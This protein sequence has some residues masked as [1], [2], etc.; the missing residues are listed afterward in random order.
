M[1]ST[2]KSVQVIGGGFSGLAAA[3]CL[4]A[5]GHE[6]NLYEKNATTGGRARAFEREG[7]LF[8]MGPSWYWMPEIIEHFFNR[9]GRSAADYYTLKL[10]D[11]S[12]RV[13]FADG[14]MDVPASYE[15][16]R[17]L[18]ES[19][20]PGSAPR[21]DRFMTEAREK[22]ETGMSRFV[23]K[24]SLN[25]TEYMHPSL[26]GKVWQLDLFSSVSR[27]V[28]KYF[29][30][31]KLIDLLEFPVLFLGAK[32]SRTPALY[33]LMNYADLKLGT[34]YPMGGMVKLPE[35]ITR[36]AAE[37]GVHIHTGAPVSAIHAERGR[38]SAI[39]VNGERLASDAVLAA[40]D[41]HHTDQVLLRENDRSYSRNYWK[42][43][44]MSPSSLLFYVGLSKK[45]PGLRHH[46]LFFDE[47]F[48]PHADSIYGTPAW[49]DKPR[50]YACCPSVTDPSVAPEGM[51]NLFLLIPAATNLQSD[52]SRREAYFK[53]L[54]GRMEKLT[55]QE[56]L[57]HVRFYQSYAHEEFI[58]DYNAF[59]GNAYGLANTLRQT[60][61]LKPAMKSRKLSNLFFAGQLTVPGPGVPPALI[62]GQLAARLISGVPYTYPSNILSAKA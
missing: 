51:E 43:R 19:V 45:I 13:F 40:C 36:M 57:P 12:Y 15:E 44:T 47:S 53:Q 26:L 33:T 46:N 4:A 42:S 34:W 21:L 25:M 3:C 37:L 54:I 27:H 61:W 35:A 6:V 30:N 55:V 24:P 23:W 8:D 1:S 49:P 2:K 31:P 48:G 60:A 9:F 5:E 62:S 11:P 56:I 41:Y 58:R 39:E 7:F 50:F 10:L 32:P 22:Y 17:A 28:R 18:F 38:I 14:P 16:L 20:E 59:G 52:P 29:K